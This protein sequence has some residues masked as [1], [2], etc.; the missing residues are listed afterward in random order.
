M[1]YDPNN[2]EN[3][4]DQETKSD[5]QPAPDR[6]GCVTAWLIFSIIANSVVALIYTFTANKLSV[7]LNTSMLCIAALIVAGAIN[8][9]C[10]VMLLS[11]R[12]I[13]FY[14]FVI[15]AALTFALNLYIGLSPFRALLGLTGIGILFAVLQIKKDGVSAWE[16]LK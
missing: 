10:A 7:Q 16:Y 15:T 1:T 12:K 3:T 11:Y 4:N 9:V 13:G 5:F 6:H 2:F 8:V 14:G